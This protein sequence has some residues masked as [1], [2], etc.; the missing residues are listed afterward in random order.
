[1]TPT[2]AISMGDPGGVGPE[3]LVKALSDAALRSRARWVVQGLENPLAL[4]AETAGVAPFWVRQ[5]PESAGPGMVLVDHEPGVG[6]GPWPASDNARAGAAS[7]RFLDAAIA[8]AQRAGPDRARAIVT[9]PISKASWALAG[10]MRFHGHTELLAHRFGDAPHAMM[11]ASPVLNVILVTAHVPLAKVP[12]LLTTP[13]IARTIRLGHEAMRTLM[14]AAP[15]IAVCG[16]N[17]H[18]GE[19]GL[20]G[21]EDT[22]VI[23]PAIELAGHDGLDVSGPF[24]ADTVFLRA[25]A[26]PARRFDLVV[27]MYH[28]QGLIP[29]KLLAR[30]TAV[31]MT[32]GL[33]V[34]RTSPDHGTAFDIAG[35]NQADP[36][37]MRAACEMALRLA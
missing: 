15:R 19:A 21:D 37:S 33:P 7:L 36:G 2:I 30:D 18:A 16:V 5:A 26:G 13:R 10:E 25:L 24:P 6:P 12:G 22:R 28:D 31:N 11:F 35:R 14:G 27:A 8:H 4:A 34:P 9:G 20:L 32:V 17:P 1:M 3:V 29:L 23:A